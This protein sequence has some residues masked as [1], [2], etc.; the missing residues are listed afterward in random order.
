LP[1]VPAERSLK[2]GLLGHGKA[3]R[4]PGKFRHPYVLL[5]GLTY[6]D[7][8]LTGVF[9][10]M[11]VVGALATLTVTMAAAQG[12]KSANDVLSYCKLAPKAAAANET[13]A[14]EYGY[15]LG[16]IDGV[17]LGGWRRNFGDPGCFD[18]PEQAFIQRGTLKVVIMYADRHPGELTQP[19][20]QVAVRALR[21]A[22]PCKA[23]L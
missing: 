9:M 17:A 12:T 2:R 10:K 16:A 6:C 14:R 7:H 15:C 23:A 18:V 4:L 13:S 20:V 21:E 5:L 8:V 19:F 3:T 22:W 11:L 1:G